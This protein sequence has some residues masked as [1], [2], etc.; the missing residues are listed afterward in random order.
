MDPKY[1]MKC[2]KLQKKKLLKTLSKKFSKP[3][4]KLPRVSS[5]S[6]SSILTFIVFALSFIPTFNDVSGYFYI[7]SSWA[8]VTTV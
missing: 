8:A 6:S 2:H 7:S 1:Y 5:F 4:I 3:T